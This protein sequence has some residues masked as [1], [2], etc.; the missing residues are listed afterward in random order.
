MGDFVRAVESNAH[1]KEL[2]SKIEADNGSTFSVCLFT[3]AE[4]Q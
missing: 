3:T 4:N 2:K 1:W